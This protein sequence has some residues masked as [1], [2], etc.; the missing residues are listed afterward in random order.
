MK[1]IRINHPSNEASALLGVQSRTLLD[2]HEWKF[3]FWAVSDE[4]E[5][6]DALSILGC[7]EEGEWNVKR[8]RST[9]SKSST[10]KKTTDGETI[11]RAGSWIY[12]FGSQYG[13]KEGELEP[14][15]HFVMRFNESLV[16]SDGDELR[17]EADLVRRPFV[18][19]RIIN[20][21][22]QREQIDLLPPGKHLHD[23]LIATL[24]RGEEKKKKWRDL[25]RKDDSPIN[26]EGSTF[27]HGGHLLLGLR[28]PVTASGQPIL[29]EV[30]GI[31][32]MF[33]SDEE[34]P[35]VIGFRIMTGVGTSKAPAGVRELDSTRDVVHVITGNLDSETKGS[36]I[37]EDHPEAIRRPCEHWIV[38]LA[39]LV[40]GLAK[41][42]AEL[43]RTFEDSSIE[44]IALEGSRVWYA[45]DAK[46]I[47]LHVAEME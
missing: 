19:H 27:L 16:E 11:A 30:E 43:A 24:E 41:V 34:L 33:D 23:D 15:R 2:A 42:E 40:G 20:D 29:V 45:Q 6:P 12:V 44:G 17:V 21:A 35:R 7:S 5:A 18:L 13:A 22:L 10:D 38:P 26:I 36:A 1:T 25:L 47:V 14:A 28:Y 32:R 46:K 4:S 39:P 31:D 8:L 9:L 37:V 3:A